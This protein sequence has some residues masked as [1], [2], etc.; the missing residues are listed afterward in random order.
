[1]IV[2]WLARSTASRSISPHEGHGI[3]ASNARRP[4][5]SAPSNSIRAG[6]SRSL[7]IGAGRRRATPPGD[8]GGADEGSGERAAARSLADA[9]AVLRDKN[10]WETSSNPRPSGLSCAPAAPSGSF[11]SMLFNPTPSAGRGNPLVHD[12]NG[13]LATVG[14]RLDRGIQRVV[15]PPPIDPVAISVTSGRQL[16]DLL[17]DSTHGLHVVSVQGPVVEVAPQLNELGGRSLDGEPD[18]RGGHCGYR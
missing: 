17:P 2:S 5:S 16:D 15:L 11:G 1:M 6:A 18:G 10:R 9:S 7:V 3:S 12:E 8:P 4:S 14:A 13:V